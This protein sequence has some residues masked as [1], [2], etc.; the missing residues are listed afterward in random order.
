MYLLYSTIEK[1]RRRKRRN[2]ESCASVRHSP[3]VHAIQVVFATFEELRLE[4]STGCSYDSVSLYDGSITNSSSLGTFCTSVLST[5]ASSGSSLFVVFR[6]D[7]SINAGRF[8]LS[9]A[10]VS[11]GGERSSTA[12]ICVS[13]A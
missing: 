3:R 11:P 6:T 8:A 1:R 9:W 12:N 2:V 10:F 7:H 5:I 13:S 4:A